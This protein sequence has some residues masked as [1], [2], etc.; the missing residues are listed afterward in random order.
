MADVALT[1]ALDNP[2]LNS[3]YEAPA[4]YFEIE[5]NVGPTGVALPGRRPS[6]SFIPVPAP[7]KGGVKAQATLQLGTDERAQRNT[8]INDIRYE[9]D[10]WRARGYPGVTP[11]SRKLMQYWADPTRE[12]RELFCQREAAE[13]AIFLAE[14]AGPVPG[15]ADFRTRVD[16]ANKLHNDGLPR[17]GLKMATG[18]GKTVVM[19]MLLAWQT[20][21]KVFSPN[22]ARFAKRFLL[23]APASPSATGYGC[24][25]RGMRV[26]IT[27]SVT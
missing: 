20:I 3:P 16:E 6:E 19:A 7:R 25:I 8:L 14:A 12:N 11:I 15:A 26:T 24:S 22:D 27:A 10:L 1:T 5:P 17:V 21:N 9:V 13:T 2:I 4:E 18:S 23:I